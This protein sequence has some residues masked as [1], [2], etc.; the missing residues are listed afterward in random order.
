M[1]DARVSIEMPTVKIPHLPP[2]PTTQAD[3]LRSP[4]RKAFEL[5]QRV[6]SKGL[7]DAGCFVSIDGEKVPKDRKIVAS[8]W[9]HTYKRG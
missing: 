9:V 5:S 6:E 2:P 7:F 1:A 4:F 3:L 8:K